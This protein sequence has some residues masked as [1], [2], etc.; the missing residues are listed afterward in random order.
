[1]RSQPVL[2]ITTRR[3]SVLSLVIVLVAMIF[4]SCK[5]PQSSQA[6]V[7]PSSNSTPTVPQILISHHDIPPDIV[8]NVGSF[9][10]ETDQDLTNDP[11]TTPAMSA[12]AAVHSSNEGTYRVHGKDV[13]LMSIRVIRTDDG[14][15]LY[16]NFDAHD[17]EIVFTTEGTGGN[18]TINIKSVDGVGG[19]KVVKFVSSDL[20]LKSEEIPP[21]NGRTHKFYNND[22]KIK[23]VTIKTGSGTLFSHITP[24]PTPTPLIPLPRDYSD[25]KYRVLIRLDIH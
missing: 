14:T 17:A 1:M 9:S 6:P 2:I 21:V 5:S 7:S 24:L 18:K 12:Q 8:I 25:K 23:N 13:L 16:Q 3:S 22:Y 11:T 15:I 20:P 4:A 10:I 19:K